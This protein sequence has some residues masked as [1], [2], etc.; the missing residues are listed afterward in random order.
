MNNHSYAVISV[1]NGHECVIDLHTSKY[2]TD[3]IYH[4]V[5][6]KYKNGFV[7]HRIDGMYDVFDSDCKIIV[8][9]LDWQDAY[10]SNLIKVRKNDMI[11]VINMATGKII[12]PK[13]IPSRVQ[14]YIVTPHDSN[15]TF[16]HQKPGIYINRQKYDDFGNFASVEQIYIDFNGKVQITEDNPFED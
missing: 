3:A 16:K 10:S 12:M 1:E 2:M 4:D 5:E 11:N 7:L 13:W 14:L 6:A 9:K 8:D 15:G